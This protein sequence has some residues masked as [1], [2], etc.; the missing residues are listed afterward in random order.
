[1]GDGDLKHVFIQFKIGFMLVKFLVRGL[2][3]YLRSLCIQHALSC[4]N[5]FYLSLANQ[6]RGGS[7]DV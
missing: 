1:M 3:L 7:R 2:F 4:A 5:S 6:Q